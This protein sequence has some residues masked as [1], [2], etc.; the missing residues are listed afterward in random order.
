[1]NI[2][3]KLGVQSYCFRGFKEN[4]K[5]AEMVRAIGVSR[6]ELCGVHANFEDASSYDKVIADYEDAGVKIVSIGV[7]G[8]A[9]NAAKEKH[10]FEFLK[11]CGGKF[12]SVDFALH[13][14]PKCLKVAEK[15]AEKYGVK[16]AIHN[17]GGAHW[18]GNGTALDWVFGQT[19]PRI[20]LCMDTAWTL[21][22]RENPVAWAERF[23]KRLHGLHIKDFIF[24]RARRPEDVVVGTGNLDLPGLF[25]ACEKAKFKG[26]AVLEYEGDVNDPVPALTKCVK[27]VQAMA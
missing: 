13:A 8:M 19:G 12:M 17:H 7:Q 20:G 10:Y 27:A 21:D 14:V 23:A 2:A 1:M 4:K 11:A 16:L 9:G 24:D 6:I 3:D 25:K 15:L 18:L 5:V 26:Y 22:S